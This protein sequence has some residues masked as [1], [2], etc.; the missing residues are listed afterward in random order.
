[1]QEGIFTRMT[2]ATLLVLGLSVPALAG[3]H[4]KNPCAA[5]NPCAVQNPCGAKAVNPCNPCAAK[6]P[7]GAAMAPTPAVARTVW[8]RVIAVNPSTQILEVGVDG[9][10]LTIGVDKRTQIKTVPDMS[11]K[12]L[13]NLKS[14]DRVAVSFVEQDGKRRA[15]FIYLATAQGAVNPCNPCAARNPCA[16]KNPC[17]GKNPCAAK[18]PCAAN[19]CAARNPCAVK[20]KWEN[21]CA[22]KE[23]R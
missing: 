1:M 8:A 22:Y 12:S 17:A 18:Q 14:G 6:N 20:E 3:Y 23:K 10:R 11:R 2:I 9:Q 5:G 7:C 15:A 4:E 13:A 19:P 21:P 16:A